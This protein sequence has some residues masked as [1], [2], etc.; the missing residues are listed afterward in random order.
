MSDNLTPLPK[1]AGC[2]VCSPVNPVGL[3]LTSRVDPGTGTV[4][5]P[6]TPGPHHVGFDGLVHGGI[7]STVADEAM[8]WAA[9][10]AT[11]RACVAGS[12]SVRFRRPTAPGDALLTVAKVVRIK[13]RLVETTAEITDAAGRA[14]A[15]AEARYLA[16]SDEQTDAFLQTL[17]ADDASGVARRHLTGASSVS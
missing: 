17:L 12:L 15:S 6:F 11:R 16:G 7:L 3:R 5:V 14:V 9:I 8:V 1:T 10:W 13:G 4:E 2:V